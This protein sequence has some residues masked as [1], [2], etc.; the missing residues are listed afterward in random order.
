MNTDNDVVEMKAPARVMLAEITLST[1]LP[2]P[3]H[4]GFYPE[5]GSLTMNFHRLV[6]GQ[7][8]ST[9]LG[10]ET[11]TYVNDDGHRYLREGFIVWHGWIVSI[12]AW[13]PAEP[14]NVLTTDMTD[15]LTQITSA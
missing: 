6:D 2:M 10:G 9:A 11:G 12:H 1:D 13:E 7:A 14:A 8:W 3:D 5:R 4:I 15:R